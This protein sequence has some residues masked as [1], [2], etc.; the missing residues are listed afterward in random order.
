MRYYWLKRVVVLDYAV[1]LQET[2]AMIL[3]GEEKGEWV[4]VE[5]SFWPGNSNY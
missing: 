5:A 1:P 3:Y 2:Q 4:D